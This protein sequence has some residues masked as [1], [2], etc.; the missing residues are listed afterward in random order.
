MRT[1]RGRRTRSLPGTR[2]CN[3][4]PAH[5]VKISKSFYLGIHEVTNAQ[6]E[7]FDPKHKALRGKRGVSK[8]GDE[9]G[10]VIG[11]GCCSLAIP[12]LGGSLLRDAVRANQA[13]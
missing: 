3:E 6:Y 11:T 5:P 8:A 2:S 12:H 1:G 10:F 9:P 4:A 13:C 7:A